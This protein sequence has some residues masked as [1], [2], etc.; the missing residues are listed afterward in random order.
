MAKGSDLTNWGKEFDQLMRMD[1]L[2]R[3]DTQ[4]EAELR[5]VLFEASDAGVDV[6]KITKKAMAAHRKLKRLGL[7]KELHDEGLL[8][9]VDSVIAVLKEEIAKRRPVDKPPST[10]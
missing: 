1:E 8:T 2:R 10:D 4:K 3:K 7:S 5:D 6:L 9:E